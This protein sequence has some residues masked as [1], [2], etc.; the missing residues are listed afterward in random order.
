MNDLLAHAIDA[1]GGLARWKAVRAISLQLDLSGGLYRIK[2]H[3]EGLKGVELRVEAHR[4]AATVTP[5]GSAGGTGHFLPARVWTTDAAGT[6][7]E[8]RSDPRA[9]FAG[10]VLT[11]RWDVLQCLY[12]SSYAMWNYLTTP[13]LL[14]EPG[15]EVREGAS[16]QENGETW[17]TLVATFSP[18]I[19][20]HCAEQTFYFS[21]KGLLQRLDYVTDVAGGVA[22]HYCYDHFDIGGILFPTLRRVVVR[23]P[24][25]PL[26]SAPTAVLLQLRDIR[27]EV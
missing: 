13:F 22:S 25:G 23:T 1:H 15:V 12:F 14:A 7:V 24:K 21:E 2:G 20:T 3:P 10:H 19:P 16:H 5:Y 6:V 9:S 4:P 18:S 26:L 27:L 17:R 8:D 11:T